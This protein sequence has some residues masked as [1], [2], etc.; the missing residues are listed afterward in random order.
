MSDVIDSVDEAELNGIIDRAKVNVRPRNQSGKPKRVITEISSSLTGIQNNFY[1]VLAHTSNIAKLRVAPLG[2]QEHIRKERQLEAPAAGV[3]G[4]NVGELAGPINHV[5]KQVSELTKLMKQLDLN[6]GSSSLIPDIDI[7]GKGRLGRLLPALP[8]AS[9]VAA[10]AA[11]AAVTGGMLYAVDRGM[12]N[13]YNEANDKLLLI[14]RRYGLRAIK[15][16]QGFT[17][18]WIVDGKRYTNN[19]LPEYYRMVLD[20]EGPTAD[21]RWGA[22]RR[23]IEYLRTHPRPGTEGMHHAPSAGTRNPVARE[24]SSGNVVIQPPRGSATETKRAAAMRASDA[25]S[26][27]LAE[28]ARRAAAGRPVPKQQPAATNEKSMA[29]RFAEKLGAFFGSLSDRVE[30]FGTSASETLSRWTN[31]GSGSYAEADVRGARGAWAQDQQFLGEVNRVSRVFNIDA[32]DLLGLMQSESRINAQ[33]RNSGTGATGLIQF[34]PSTARGLGTSTDELARMSRAQ[35]MRFVEAYFHQVRLPRGANAGQL[36]GAVFLPGRINQNPLTRA[37]ERYYGPNAGLDV[38]RN[39]DI[40]Q[41]DLIAKVSRKRQEIGLGPSRTA[42]GF[43]AV[44]GVVGNFFGGMIDSATST[45]TGRGRFIQPVASPV[46][47]SP[48]GWRIHPVTHERKMHQGIDFGGRVGTPIHAVASG[49]VVFADWE[50][51]S[52]PGQGY[53]LYTKIDHG[54]GFVSLYGHLSGIRVRTGQQITQGQQ[55]GSMGSTGRSTGP[56]LHFGLQRSGTFV[57]PA[58]L[59]GPASVAPGGPSEPGNE[60]QAQRQP[61]APRNGGVGA[62]AGDVAANRRASRGA[63]PGSIPGRG[64]G[65]QRVVRAPGTPAPPRAPQPDPRPWYTRYFG[66]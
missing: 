21:P 13:T 38:D 25:R 16:E 35:Q 50:N 22:T 42:G 31:A 49:T 14:E 52:N 64:G 15:N 37:G 32:N 46:V 10:A 8:A 61:A 56:H 27:M 1:A 54:N 6:S 18:G 12:K 20:A 26:R 30:A 60:A 39:G 4:S 9:T 3:A 44:A 45:L 29:D 5:S 19:N 17:S 65:R 28:T 33:A 47:T 53:G 63:A 51:R 58:S 34:M 7:G 59:L 2:N 62:T 66:L 36:Y 11:A 40:S 23:A 57:N 43:S 41:Q 24:D 55:I 48:F